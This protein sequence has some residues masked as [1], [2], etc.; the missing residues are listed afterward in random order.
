VVRLRS[1]K[2]AHTHKHTHK[3]THT[4]VHTHAHTCTHTHARARSLS[5]SRC[6]LS[7][8]HSFHSSLLRAVAQPSP[9]AAN[10]EGQHV[11]SSAY[12]MLQMERAGGWGRAH[13]NV[14]GFTLLFLIP[15]FLLP[16]LFSPLP[17]ARSSTHASGTRRKGRA[18]GTRR[19]A[20]RAPPTQSFFGMTS[21]VFVWLKKSTGCFVPCGH[22]CVCQACAHAIMETKKECP[23][24]G[25]KAAQI[26]AVFL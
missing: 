20:R 10:G 19:K 13:L 1:H 18:S 22:R 6:L 3:H 21:V 5:L 2:H 16:S 9:H 15:F 17:L 11:S 26:F 25:Q 8:S 4:H 14:C 24:C 12:D 7:L 23:Y